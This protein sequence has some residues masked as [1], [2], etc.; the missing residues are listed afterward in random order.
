MRRFLVCLLAL[1][2]TTALNAD[3]KKV[4]LVGQGSDGHPPT[5]HEF[6][7]GVRVIA[8]L[9]EHQPNLEVTVVSADGA[10]P[11][12]PDLI[13]RSDCVVLYLTQGFQWMQESEERHLALMELTKNGGGLMALHWAVGAKDPKFIEGGLKLLGG[14]HG[15]PD[16][17]YIVTTTKLAPAEPMHP[18]ATGVEA[19]EVKDEFY[20]Q[21]KFVQPEGSITPVMQATINDQPE[22]VAWAWERPDGGRSFGFSGLHFHENW[23]RNEYRRL[24]ANAVLWT[25][26]EPIPDGGAPIEVSEDVY[27]L[28]EAQP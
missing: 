13:R 2:G 10:W 1:W 6:R 26:Q 20:Y 16:R 23:K 27:H 12:G 9:L 3:P 11:E 21:L 28:E 14:C 8:A 18:I 25:A 15:G 4:L 7:A 19:L 17:Q 24:V 5:T 22:T